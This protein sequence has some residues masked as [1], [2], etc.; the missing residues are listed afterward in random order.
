MPAL[1]LSYTNRWSSPLSGFCFLYL[2]LN[3]HMILGFVP[4]TRSSRNYFKTEKQKISAVIK[5]K[6]GYHTRLNRNVP[7]D[8][9]REWNRSDNNSYNRRGRNRSSSASGSQRGSNPQRNLE[10]SI[11][12]L[13][14]ISSPGSKG[15]GSRNPN[16]NGDTFRDSDVSD[17]N[18]SSADYQVESDAPVLNGNIY[19]NSDDYLDENGSIKG[20]QGEERY[21]GGDDMKELMKSIMNEKPEIPKQNPSNNGSA[22]FS[23]QGSSTDNQILSD[24][25]KKG[26]SNKVNSAVDAE[27]LHNRIFEDEKGFMNQ[28]EV[29]KKSLSAKEQKEQDDAT[30]WRR[31][32]EYRRRQEEAM[33]LIEKD[34]EEV[35]N[36]SLSIEDARKLA[37]EQ[38]QQAEEN[39]DMVGQGPTTILCKQ[40]ACLLSQEEIVYENER[41]R[42]G[43][44]EK[45]CRLCHIDLRK[46]KH[47]SP[48]LMGRV[49]RDGKPPPRQGITRDELFQQK[50]DELRRIGPLTGSE[51]TDKYG[52]VD[53]QQNKSTAPSE[54]KTWR[55]SFAPRAPLSG[56]MAPTVRSSSSRTSARP[57]PVEAKTASTTTSNT[58][59]DK[60]LTISDAN[61]DTAAS[62]QL[63]SRYPN[64]LK[65]LVEQ[66]DQYK[67][68]VWKAI[69]NSAKFRQDESN[70]TYQ[71]RDRKEASNIESK[72]PF[73]GN[74]KDLAIANSKIRELER[75]VERYKMELEK[76]SKV[77]KAL[78]N[79][80]NVKEKNSIQRRRDTGRTPKNQNGRTGPNDTRGRNW[81]GSEEFP[82]VP[83]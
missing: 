29:F 12:N 18:I 70:N 54:A 31:A 73:E 81:G 61:K 43:A 27:E 5:D 76:S 9:D 62:S 83:F 7:D 47:G 28:S 68:Q 60:E 53:E 46:S 4:L 24:F 17:I 82:D 52:V 58:I 72:G 34:M 48:Y 42:T 22:K 35:E 30:A 26:K 51:D 14:D 45:F 64:R 10:S 39:S 78:Q 23:Q 21:Y 8:S 2:W 44:N 71:N 77:A 63:N 74:T 75:V 16:Q 1:S 37:A 3:C 40:C 56:K 6:I 59:P 49:A 19:H 57:V 55:A 11:S 50:E 33:S 20:R 36:N 79:I 41:G 32:S 69:F 67:P 80:I 15:R 13:F 25:L 65:E 38:N 66:K